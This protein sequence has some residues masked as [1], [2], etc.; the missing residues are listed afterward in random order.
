M[1]LIAG[2]DATITSMVRTSSPDAATA[3]FLGIT[4]LGDARYI[5]IVALALAIV[6]IKHDR[7]GYAAGLTVSLIGSLMG[8]YAI[9]LLIERPRPLAPI[10]DVAGYAFPSMHAACAMGLY[11]F[12]I[13]AVVRLMHPPHHRAPIVALLSALILL[14]GISRVYLGAHYPSDIVGGFVVGAVFVWLGMVIERRVSAT[15]IRRRSRA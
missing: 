14:I 13:Y 3:V 15:K 11:G 10:L 2:F 6:L 5:T 8:S 9:K 12:L 7:L 4:K 1:N